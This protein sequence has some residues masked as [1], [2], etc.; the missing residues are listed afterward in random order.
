V[1]EKLRRRLRARAL[2][3][4]AGAA[5]RLPHAA[6]E[7]ALAALAPL[8]RFSSFETMTQKNL[9][10]AL[11]AEVPL[12]GRQRIAREVRQHTARLVADW[13]RLAR[14]S[15]PSDDSAAHVPHGA[16][17]G[18][19][20]EA[21]VELDAS[22]AHLEAEL[23]KGRGALVVTAHLGNWELLAARVRRAGYR[24][25]VVGYRRPNDSSAAWLASMRRAYGVETLAQ[26]E[27]PREILRALDRGLVVGLLADLEVRRLDG[28]F[29]PF[30]GV[31]ALTMTAPAAIARARGSP[32]L[33]ARCVFDAPSNRYRLAFD[34]PLELDRSL[35]R[36]AA[37]L[38]LTERLN[39]TFEAWIRAAP[40][41]WAWHQPR[42]RTRPGDHAPIPFHGRREQARRERESPPTLRDPARSSIF[43]KR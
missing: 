33:P 11:G 15:P 13:V 5:G 17:R 42:W 37:T 41:Q 32:L 24:G 26:Q 36:R 40:G 30:F 2:A 8:A 4:I 39:R 7:S 34:A 12:A 14:S 9:E 16:D 38:D 20:I 27:N 10:L 3:G 23:A 29:L 31:P 28:E 22:V 1:A 19:W 43:T 18:A 35:E 6:V 25:V 21:R